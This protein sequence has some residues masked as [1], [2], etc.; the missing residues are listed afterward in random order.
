MRGSSGAKLPDSKLHYF[1]WTAGP[2]CTVS[3]TWE[4]AHFLLQQASE[5]I[6]EG[7]CEAALVV[8]AHLNRYPNVTAQFRLMGLASGDGATRSFDRDGSYYSVTQT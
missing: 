4:D 2:S 7:E 5:S 6:R 8:A 3:C 1:R